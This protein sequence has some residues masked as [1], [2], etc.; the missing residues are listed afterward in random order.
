M[1]PNGSVVFSSKIA[2][3]LCTELVLI[4][5][6][7]ALL[8]ADL[9]PSLLVDRSHAVVGSVNRT[10]LVLCYMDWAF[11][12]ADLVPT[13]FLNRSNAVV[14]VVFASMVTLGG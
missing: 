2:F 13:L 10:T 4:L 7:R 6:D 3:N 11:L 12:S 5:L 1:V 14:V 9:V 8:W